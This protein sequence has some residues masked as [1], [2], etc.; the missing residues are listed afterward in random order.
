M[1]VYTVG[2]FNYLAKTYNYDYTL[3]IPTNFYYE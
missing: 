1:R 3:L 2:K